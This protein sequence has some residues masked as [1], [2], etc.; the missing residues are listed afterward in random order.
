L[1]AVTSKGIYDRGPYPE[2][3]HDVKVSRPVRE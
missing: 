2:E 1:L 3:P